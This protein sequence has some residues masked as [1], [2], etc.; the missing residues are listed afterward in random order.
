MCNKHWEAHRNTDGTRETK[1]SVQQIL[2]FRPYI[3]LSTLKKR[4]TGAASF[5]K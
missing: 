4:F 1:H 5:V 3:E 2:S